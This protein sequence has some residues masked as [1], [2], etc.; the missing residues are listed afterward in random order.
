MPVEP[1]TVPA[2]ASK[3]ESSG[4]RAGQPRPALI[5]VNSSHTASAADGHHGLDK[6]DVQWAQNWALSYMSVP[7]RTN[8]QSV[9][10]GWISPDDRFFRYQRDASLCNGQYIYVV[11]NQ[12]DTEHPVSC[13]AGSGPFMF[14]GLLRGPVVF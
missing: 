7:P 8:V 1:L 9:S 12:I 4:S 10:N 6:R 13:P 5:P 3:R 14:L 2:S 11:E